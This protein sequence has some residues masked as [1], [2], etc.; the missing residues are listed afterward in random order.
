MTR[1]EILDEA[2]KCVCGDREQDY[3]TPE[4]NFTTIANFWI[5]YFTGKGQ[6]IDIS[7]VDVAAMM[8]LVKIA[9]ISSGHAKDDNWIDLCG[10]AA[11]GGEIESEA[12]KKIVKPA[13]MKVLTE[14]EA[15]DLFESDRP[16]PCERY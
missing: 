10:Y 8:A 4:Q 2:K 16:D 7:A 13:A 6:P 1:P 15:K 3:G 9:R 12:F 14:E 11:C 5:D